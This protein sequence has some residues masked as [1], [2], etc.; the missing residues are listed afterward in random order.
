M[1]GEGDLELEEGE[2]GGRAREGELGMA[3]EVK[4]EEYERLVGWLMRVGRLEG[5]ECRDGSC[6]TDFPPFFCIRQW[7]L[8]QFDLRPYRQPDLDIPTDK[9][10]L[11]RHALQEVRFLLSITHL[12]L[13]LQSGILV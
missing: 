5:A 12:K 1:R 11:N 6:F 9:H 3:G 7:I 10:F 4:R 2:W 13:F 8:N